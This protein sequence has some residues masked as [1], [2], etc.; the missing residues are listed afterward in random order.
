MNYDNWK[1]DNGF[2]DDDYY[3]STCEKCEEL[4]EDDDLNE[5]TW[6]D[7]DGDRKTMF[8]CEGCEHKVVYEGDY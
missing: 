6:R 5:V 8:L 3:K 7:A 2:K 4:F 1:L